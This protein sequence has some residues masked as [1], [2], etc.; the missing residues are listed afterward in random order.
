M[1]ANGGSE[2]LIF[3]PPAAQSH[4]LSLSFVSVLAPDP[5]CRAGL[6]MGLEWRP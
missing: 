2:L 6:R 4:D 5:L 3:I 1:V